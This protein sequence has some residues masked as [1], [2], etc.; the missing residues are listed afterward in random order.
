MHVRNRTRPP[1]A[2]WVAAIGLSLL[3]EAGAQPSSA[4]PQADSAALAGASTLKLDTLEI[5]RVVLDKPLVHADAGGRS[6]TWREAYQV[7]LGV[8]APPAPGP[9]LDIFLGE[10][11]VSEYGEWSRGIYFWVYDPV[12]LKQLDGRRIYYRFGR[13]P[14]RD[15]GALTLGSLQRL[16][17]VPE[18]DLP[19]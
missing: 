12:R 13:G 3:L 9:A 17:R 18:R 4:R 10:E 14:K 8:A 15:L 5:H 1:L 19:K 6:R 16:K 11:R 2:A 7:R